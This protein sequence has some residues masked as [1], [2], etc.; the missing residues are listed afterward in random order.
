MTRK[1]CGHFLLIVADCLLF[2]IITKTLTWCAFHD[3]GECL[4]LKQKRHVNLDDTWN[5]GKYDKSV[6]GGP[7]ND[8]YRFFSYFSSRSPFFSSH[9]GIRKT[10]LAHLAT[11][12]IPIQ[13][14]CCLKNAKTGAR[15]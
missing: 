3:L 15:K 5:S 12:T 10:S 1:T 6:Q 8:T 7:K 14:K 4:I 2:S 11:Q 13:N 9:Y